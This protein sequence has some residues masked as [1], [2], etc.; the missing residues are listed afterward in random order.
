MTIRPASKGRS[1]VV[2]DV[3][4]S[5]H[6]FGW[7]FGL[8]ADVKITSPDDVVEEYRK[9]IEEQLKGYK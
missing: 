8:G 2:V 7:V 6:F 5:R 9:Q 3:A 1:F 4:V